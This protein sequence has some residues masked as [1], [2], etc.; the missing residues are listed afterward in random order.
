MLAAAKRAAVGLTKMADIE[1]LGQDLQ[2]VCINDF[3]FPEL[4]PLRFSLL[5]V[6]RSLARQARVLLGEHR[7]NRRK[8]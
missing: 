8:E 1:L 5:R 7:E 2:E 4:T 6:C 3:L